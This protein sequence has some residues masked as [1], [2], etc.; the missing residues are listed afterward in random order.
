VTTANF[1]WGDGIGSGEDNH[2]DEPT[3]HVYREP[4]MYLAKSRLQNLY[5]DEFTSIHKVGDWSRLC[6]VHIVSGDSH[7]L[8]GRTGD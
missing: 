4:G 8:R 3:T 7:T 5:V 1:D 6:T 2:L